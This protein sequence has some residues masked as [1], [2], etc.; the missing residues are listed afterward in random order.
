[1]Y[2]YPECDDGG[3]DCNGKLQ[4]EPGLG[5]FSPFVTRTRGGVEGRIGLIDHGGG[6][7]VA[8][9]PRASPNINRESTSMIPRPLGAHKDVYVISITWHGVLCHSIKIINTLHSFREA[10]IRLRGQSSSHHHHD[11]RRIIDTKHLRTARAIRHACRA[12][13]TGSRLGLAVISPSST[14]PFLCFVEWES[15]MGPHRDR[16]G[17]RVQCRM[18]D[19]VDLFWAITGTRL[20]QLAL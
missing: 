10:T 9:P 13:R 14:V 6:M 17:R 8:G 3:S 1:M 11:V 15:T 5:A 7:L 2:T 18:S 20:T 4:H 16:A 19:Q 12:D